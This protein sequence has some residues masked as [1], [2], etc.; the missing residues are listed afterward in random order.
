MVVWG[1]IEPQRIAVIAASIA[2]TA[3]ATEDPIGS[4]RP[5]LAG[6]DRGIVEKA[7]RIAGPTSSEQST[8]PRSTYSRWSAMCPTGW[9][10]AAAA[11]RW[12]VS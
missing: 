12:R 11:S 7:L 8:C 9:T 3:S 6:V 10:H 2:P 5:N 1:E 4:N